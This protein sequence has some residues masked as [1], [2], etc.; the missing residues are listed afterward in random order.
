MPAR[1]I[2]FDLDGTLI[3]SRR[4][5]ADSANQ[6]LASYGAPP[7][8]EE[9]VGKMVGSGAAQLVR[10]ALRAA[11]VTAPLEDALARFLRL[12]DDRLTIHTRP[13]AGVPEMLRRLNTAGTKVA[14]LTNKPLGPSIRILEAFDL[15][16]YFVRSIGGDG[17]W[18]RKPSPAGLIALVTEHSERPD[19]TVLVGDS[20]I[21]LQTARNAGVRFGLARYGFGFS[22]RLL[23]AVAPDDLV[24][25]DPLGVCDAVGI[26]DHTRVSGP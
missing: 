6:M 10:R 25:D 12:Y 9:E 22:D 20:E 4:D 5:L 17:P 16:R 18:P 21:D 24:L 7:L 11:G 15:A 8:G 13:Y 14:L 1:L 23:E 3:D 2:V 26:V 19:T